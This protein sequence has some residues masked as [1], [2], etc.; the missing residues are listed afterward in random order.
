VSEP[1][2]GTVSTT[3]Q[4]LYAKLFHGRMLLK[5]SIFRIPIPHISLSVRTNRRRSNRVTKLLCPVMYDSDKL[6]ASP[7]TGN[8][9]PGFQAS[10]HNHR[11]PDFNAT[12]ERLR[13]SS[14][15][16][17]QSREEATNPSMNPGCMNDIAR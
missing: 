11:C 12:F 7:G 6:T 4:A 15:L 5:S 8:G 1:R 17:E 10:V 13:R 3:G 16:V 9:S 2:C 14:N